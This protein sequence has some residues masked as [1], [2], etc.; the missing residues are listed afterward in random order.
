MKWIAAANLAS[1]VIMVASGCNEADSNPDGNGSEPGETATDTGN[2]GEQGSDTGS[3]GA[4]PEDTA[5]EG[6]DPEDTASEDTDP[7]M[8]LDAEVDELPAD[9]AAQYRALFAEHE[10]S[11]GM[12]AEAFAEKYAVPF[13]ADLDFDPLGAA[14]LTLIQDST[15]ALGE[16]A[17][18]ALGKNGFVILKESAAPTFFNAYETVYQNDLPVY[19]TADSILDAVH[20]SYDSILEAVE[21]ELLCEELTSLLTSMRSGLTA[22]DSEPLDGQIVQDLD[23]YLAVA[24]SLLEGETQ[25]PVQGADAAEIRAFVDL[26]TAADG[27]EEITLFGVDRLM[28]FS[29]FT[30]RGHYDDGWRLEKYFKAMMWLGRIDFRLVET[31]K[32]GNRVLNRR[33]V[34]ATLAVE[35]LMTEA[36][37]AAWARINRAVEAFVGKS[38]N[39][40]IEQ[41]PLLMADL[42]VADL[43]GLTDV[44]DETLKGTI[45]SGG[46]GTQQI[47][48]HL[49]VNG[50]M[51]G[52]LPLNA[53]FL[54][55]GQRYVVDSHVF[56]NLVYDRVQGGNVYRMMPDPL[57]VS[58]AALGNDQAADLLSD[59]LAA[60]HYAPDLHMTRVLVDSHGDDFWSENLYTL[61]L[62]ALRSLSPGDELESPSAAGLSTVFATEPWGRRMLNAQLGSWAELRHDTLLYAKQSYTGI[63]EC[64]YPDAYVDPYPAFF[65]AVGRYAEK[66]LAVAEIAREGGASY[67]ASGIESYFTGLGSVADRLAE[68]AE[69]QR[70]GIPFTDEQLA[71][72]NDT[73]YV[74]QR[75]VVCAMVDAPFGWYADLFFRAEELPPFER[76]PVIA[77][78]HTQPADEGGAIVGRVLHVAVGE[79]RMMVI[80]VNTCSGPRAYVGPVFSYFEKITEDFERLTDSD[81]A[82]ELE[83]GT[84]PDVSWMA[85]V[86]A[87]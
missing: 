48:S 30:P 36:D 31:D 27:M 24:L 8:P 23:F 84:P 62:G 86:L 50:M 40:T 59:E 76:D 32:L 49:M 51:S 12:T 18:T 37:R 5:P 9:E 47:C 79:P 74:A 13:A 77:D 54:L 17:L 4:S 25:A 72:I 3:G 46:Y 63:P 78:V 7:V 85:P 42:G 69:Q 14:N 34:E 11:A 43:S 2:T 61:W 21:L 60:F 87:R 52:T 10:A 38:D 19:I 66:G 82:E 81:W 80:T 56:S 33:Q 35:A 75:D 45:L 70:D 57:D 73:V 44:D 16:D 58:F 29:Q 1:F 6:T 53:G 67:L 28:D 15:L 55:F 39:M 41:I 26:A 83:T 20:R 71:F 22:L 64:E 68:M 65:E